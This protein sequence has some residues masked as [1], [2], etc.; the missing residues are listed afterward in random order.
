[1]IEQ[2]LK[3]M[4]ASTCNVMAVDTV[5]KEL[6]NAGFTELR[7]ADEW[8]L[9]PG[10]K[11]YMTQNGTAVF[12]FVAG[13]GDVAE[14]GFHIISS[15]SDSPCFKIKPNAEIYG[16]GGVLKLN[17]EKYGGG[18]LY[19]WFDRPLSISGRV[20]VRTA[21]PLKPEMLKVDLKRAICTIPHLAIHFN[22]A[23][24]EGN[25][26]SVQRDM[27]PVV[28]VFSDEEIAAYKEQGGFLRRLLS[29]HLSVDTDDILDY[30]LCLYP[31]EP[32]TLVGMHGEL[33]QS[34]RIDDLSMAF[35]SLR[36]LLDTCD[37][38]AKATRVMAIF[39]NEETG[40]GTKQ[41]AHSPILRS[42]LERICECISAQQTEERKPFSPQTFHRAVANSFMISADDAHAWH[43]N[44]NEKYDPTNHPVIGGGPVVKIN[45]NCKYMTDAQGAAVFRMLCKEAGVPCQTFVNHSDVA[46]GSTLGNILT[47]Q[48]DIKGVD[49]GNA[50]WAMHSARETA[51]VAD[52][53][54]T[55][56]AFTRFFQD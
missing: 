3:W 14:N 44:Y 9:E 47:G 40:S 32:A 36:A 23:V 4:D 38:P 53:L 31:L 33:F 17:V 27:L 11:Y 39:D 2:L 20:A 21:D 12:A 48:L 7:A 43:P 15:H 6:K 8:H 46:G 54:H 19:T 18:I 52:H 26:I 34:G 25:P 5:E 13:S 29:A 45:S 55:V 56:A 10:G 41:G 28:G 50:I 35:A 51:G 16:Q 30:E 42:M 22:R 24:N 1:M 37:T 49:M